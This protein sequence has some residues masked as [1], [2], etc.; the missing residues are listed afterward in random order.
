METMP[1]CLG[2]VEVSGRL[3]GERLHSEAQDH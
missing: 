1:E 3:G 2:A